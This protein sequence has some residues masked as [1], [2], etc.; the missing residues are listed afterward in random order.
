MLLQLRTP[1]IVHNGKNQA[2]PIPI[3]MPA[4]SP[5]MTEGNLAKWMVKEGDTVSAGEVIVEI[6][7]D[8]ATMEVEA[9]DDGIL[10]KIVVDSGT[11]GV[12][13]NAVIAYLL[14]EGESIANI[15]TEKQLSPILDDEKDFK[16]HLL[17]SNACSTAQDAF[18]PITNNDKRVFASPLARRLAKQTEVN[19]SNIIG[20]GPKGRIVKNDVENVIAILPPKDILCESSTKQSSSFIQPNVPDYNEITNTTMRK[21]IAKRLVESK[22]CAPHF[23]LTIDCEIDELLRVRKELNAKSNDYKISL[24][25]LLIRAVAI[26]LRHTPNANSVWT[27]DAIRVYRQIDI[28]VAVAIKGGLITPVIRD[29]GSKGLVEISSL[30]KDLITRARDNKLLPEEYQGGTFSIS[31]LGMFGIKDFAAVINPPQAAIMAVG[32]AEERPVV[33]DGKLGIATVMSCTLS[34]DHRV[35]DGAVAADFLNTFRRLI[36]NPLTMLL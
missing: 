32:T 2:M 5:T 27:D 9:V 11:S 23:Y 16:E 33:K 7:T 19:L 18:N 20:T 21:V 4:L 31:N 28:A 15:P 22:R 13:V 6:E 8:K 25:D 30:M 17:L 35:I 24:N 14:E 36:E 1:A 10:G 3:T 26:A 34:A 12:A 29:V